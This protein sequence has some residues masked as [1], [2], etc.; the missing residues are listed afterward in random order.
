MAKSIKAQVAE[1]EYLN[2]M[3]PKYAN[4]YYDSLKSGYLSSRMYRW[5]D[6]YNDYRGTVAWAQF[7][8]KNGSDPTHDAFDLFA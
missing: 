2:K 5:I 4:A 1:L 8:Q 6:T 7:C 3:L